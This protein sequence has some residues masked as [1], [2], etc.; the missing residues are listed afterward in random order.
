M[1]TITDMNEI[2]ISMSEHKTTEN[3]AK[4]GAFTVSIGTEDTVVA[5]DPVNHTYMTLG[6]KVGN[7][8]KDGK[9]HFWL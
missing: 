6:E 5:Y 4:T 8:F 3:F 7:A 2:S 1:G 9:V